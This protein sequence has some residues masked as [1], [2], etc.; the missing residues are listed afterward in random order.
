MSI[1]QLSLNAPADRQATVTYEC[2]DI[3][4]NKLQSELSKSLGGGGLKLF[5]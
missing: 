3:L 2:M 4:W 1:I 5:L